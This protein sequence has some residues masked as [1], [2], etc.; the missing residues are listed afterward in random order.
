M[1][2]RTKYWLILAALLVACAASGALIFTQPLD[3]PL[4]HAARAAIERRDFS[5]GLDD[6]HKHLDANPG[7]L[8]ARL[9]AVEAARRDGNLETA[10][11]H[12]QEFKKAGGPETAIELQA[13]LIAVQQGDPQQAA[14]V[15]AFCQ[16]NPDAAET[17]LALESLIMA[18]LYR[19]VMPLTG[20]KSFPQDNMPPEVPRL[21]QAVD[22]WLQKRPALADQVQGLV[23]RGRVRGFRGDHAGAVAD[24]QRA[25]EL[26]PEHF[27]AAA[28]LAL[29]I[30]QDEPAE[31]LRQMERLLERFPSDVRI[32]YAVATGRRNLGD[33]DG[34]RQLL[35][36]ILRDYPSGSQALLER[37]LVELDA[38]NPDKAKPFLDRAIRADPEYPE[39]YLGLS[40]YMAMVGNPEA[41]KRH[42]DRFLALDAKRNRP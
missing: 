17:P 23:W 8:T 42:R 33:T 18:D 41:A 13:R 22:I 40:R 39:V 9:M 35:D 12:L 11:A 31:S 30:G 21:E 27:E 38:K 32:Q 26:D 16:A 2:I 19:L 28:Y 7:D 10:R 37:G 5:A 36:A 25:A 24:L 3:P 20:E 14:L 34:A 1:S 6:L 4:V 29:S 15:F